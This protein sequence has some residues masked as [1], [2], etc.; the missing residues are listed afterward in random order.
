MQAWAALTPPHAIYRV[1]RMLYLG[2]MIPVRIVSL[3]S[4]A[5]RRQ[6][7]AD[8]FGERGIPFTFFDAVDGRKMSA[9]E[10]A[11]LDP[12]RYDLQL[13]R[14]LS[15]G[16]IGVAASFRALLGEI[17]SG[18]DK[19]TAVF[20]DDTVPLEGLEHFLQTETL[21]RLP[22]FDVLR[23]YDDVRVPRAALAVMAAKENGAC[24][25]IPVKAGL[26]CVAQVVTRD[27]ARKIAEAIVPLRAPLDNLIYR[28]AWVPDLRILQVR[29]GVVGYRKV[30]D[31]RT[32]IGGVVRGD[33]NFANNTRR[34]LGLLRR[35]LRA[36][37]RLAATWG[38]GTLLKLRIYK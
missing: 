13:G 16:E 38:A 12:R 1:F 24:V 34:K 19:Y 14:E 30:G 26:G 17:A 4:S 35:N 36:A 8:V 23:L 33:K 11:T 2:A 15:P 3:Q 21:S 28:D 18:N 5:D 27:G 29:P 10:I 9:A 37:Y 7:C 31:E 25:Y 20:E 32:T 6:H 22:T